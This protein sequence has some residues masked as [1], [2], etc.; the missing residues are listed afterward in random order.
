MKPPGGG[1]RAVP[2]LRAG[3]VEL[4]V[5][6]LPQRRR[7]R[8]EGVADEG[9]APERAQARCEAGHA[10]VPQR[11]RKTGSLESAAVGPSGHTGGGEG[12]GD[13]RRRTEDEGRPPSG[14]RAGAGLRGRVRGARVGRAGGQEDD[15]RWGA[16]ER[17][18]EAGT[19]AT[20]TRRCLPRLP[21]EMMC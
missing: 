5:R 14:M 7:Q 16:W 12:G 11:A 20:L 17:V 18:R 3:D 19:R 13:V 1:P 6:P 9:Q 10:P 21:M 8:G 4:N 15:G 2:A